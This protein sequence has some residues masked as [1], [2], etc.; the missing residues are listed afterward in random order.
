MLDFYIV[1]CFEHN[2][3]WVLVVF[4]LW[5]V[6]GGV[7]LVDDDLI[8]FFQTI[9]FSKHLIFMQRLF[10]VP[11]ASRSFIG[12][13]HQQFNTC[14]IIICDFPRNIALKKSLFYGLFHYKKFTKTASDTSKN[15]IKSVQ[16]PFRVKSRR[17][18]F[19]MQIV[20]LFYLVF[21]TMDL[22]MKMHFL[23]YWW[24]KHRALQNKHSNYYKNLQLFLLAKS[25]IL[26]EFFHNFKFLVILLVD[27][28][29]LSKVLQTNTG[30]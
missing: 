10:L 25:I 26:N 22:C 2:Y 29:R 7:G 20:L 12:S 8:G 21:L 18:S 14:F 23:L 5:S 15:P 17:S 27:F 24:I 19:P 16:K 3:R 1:L 9:L 4:F 30:I 11:F 28:K 13:S 6:F